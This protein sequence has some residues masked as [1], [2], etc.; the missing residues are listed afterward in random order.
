MT[1]VT[2]HA[3][4]YVSTLG[5]HVL[6]LVKFHEQPDAQ[7]RQVRGGSAFEAVAMLYVLRAGGGARAAC[8]SNPVS[9]HN[10]SWTHELTCVPG[11]YA[12]QSHTA[13]TVHTGFPRAGIASLR[14]ARAF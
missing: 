3:E 2:K 14:T 4:K 6:G 10:C 12:R 1:H 13:T 7:W 9:H 8:I 5:G 11:I